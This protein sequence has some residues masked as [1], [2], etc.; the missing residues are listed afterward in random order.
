M[1]HATKLNIIFLDI[2]GV[3]NTLTSQFKSHINHVEAFDKNGNFCRIK[4]IENQYLDHSCCWLLGHALK[5]IPNSVII[6]SSTW[7][8]SNTSMLSPENIAV[9]RLIEK[10]GFKKI[11]DHV[12]NLPSTPYGD[13]LRGNEIEQW[14]NTHKQLVDN[15]A[16]IDDDSDVLP[17]QMDRFVKCNYDSGFSVR[18]AGK[19]CDLFCVKLIE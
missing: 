1:Q 17:S 16:I 3:L 2:D 7:R 19:L 12:R 11:S 15:Y 10:F 14:L 5:R 6:L 9:M 18:E 4:H 13:K 8:E